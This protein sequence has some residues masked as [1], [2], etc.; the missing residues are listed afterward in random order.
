MNRFREWLYGPCI[1]APVPL[2]QVRGA[3]RRLLDGE[4]TERE[5]VAW[6]HCHVGHHGPDDLQDLVVLDDE[7]DPNCVT[8]ADIRWSVDGVAAMVQARALEVAA[9]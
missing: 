4:M 3:A 8:D 7:Y 9:E 1:D 6:I 2:S 5:F